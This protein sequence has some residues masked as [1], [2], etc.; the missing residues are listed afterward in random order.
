MVQGFFAVVYF[1]QEVLCALLTQLT[2]LSF[3]FLLVQLDEVKCLS[4]TSLIASLTD[5]KTQFIQRRHGSM[6]GN[7]ALHAVSSRC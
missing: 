4:L 3:F 7:P 2:F 6:E 1:G 5:R